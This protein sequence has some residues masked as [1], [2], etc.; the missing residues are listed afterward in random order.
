MFALP[1]RIPGAPPTCRLWVVASL[2]DVGGT[3][4]TFGF[5]RLASVFCV[6]GWVG[7]SWGL[8][9]ANWYVKM[10]LKM[11]SGFY[12]ASWLVREPSIL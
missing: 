7:I 5:A 2:Q 8:Q 4:I 1:Y 11:Y 6:A 12:F 10:G 9:V 3:C